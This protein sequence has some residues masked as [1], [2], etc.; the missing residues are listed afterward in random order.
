MCWGLALSFTSCYSLWTKANGAATISDITIHWVLHHNEKLHSEN[1]ILWHHNPLAS[2]G[3]IIH[4][5]SGGGCIVLHMPRRL[6]AGN[7]WWTT[8]QTITFCLQVTKYTHPTGNIYLTPLKAVQKSHF[9]MAS[10]SKPQLS[11]YN[12]VD[13]ISNMRVI[14]LAAD[15]LEHRSHFSRLST[16]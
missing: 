12:A 2:F 4:S 1:D 8:L 7:I 6:K 10:S 15:T 16:Q 9:V 13:S 14:S 11:N 3:H 5:T